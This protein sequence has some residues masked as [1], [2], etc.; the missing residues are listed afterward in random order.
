ML[1]ILLCLSLMFSCTIVFSQSECNRFVV[2]SKKVIQKTF[3]QSDSA[4][5]FLLDEQVTGK[6]SVNDAG[7]KETIN[8]DFTFKD[9]QGRPAEMRDILTI[10]FQDQKA[11]FIARSKRLYTGKITFAIIRP[12]ETRL[13]TLLTDEDEL[14]YRKLKTDRITY[15]E[16][17]INSKSQKMLLSREKSEWLKEVIICLGKRTNY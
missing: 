15:L 7:R 5:T 14:F 6:L 9:K 10:H 2:K 16:L 17:T 4:L 1:K 11:E 13:G 8:F 3:Y 12:T